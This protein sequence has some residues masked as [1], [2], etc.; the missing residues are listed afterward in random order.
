MMQRSLWLGTQVLVAAL[1]FSTWEAAAEPAIQWRA[2]AECPPQD[3]LVSR[4]EDL[5]GDALKSNLTATTDVTRTRTAYRAQLRIES[6]TGIG[7]RVLENASC[8]LLADSVALVIALASQAEPPRSERLTWTVSAHVAGLLGP[9]PHA[10]LGF[11]AD[12][13]VEGLAA[14]RVAFSGSYYL[15]QSKTFADGPEGADFNLVAFGARVCR[16]WSFDAFDLAPCLGAELYHMSARG[17]GGEE[18]LPGQTTFWGPA[19][20]IFAR[21]RLLD[22]FAIHL[23]ADGVVP[24]S[25]RSFVYSD[26]GQLHRASALALQLLVAAEVRF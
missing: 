7:E 5:L 21:V 10:G 8:D 9:L 16:L 11:G 26:V 22:A 19:A 15:P 14:L 12:V 17:F 3:A 6:P 1:L 20:G 23:A 2:P 13:A 4:V 18:G 25:R 24:L